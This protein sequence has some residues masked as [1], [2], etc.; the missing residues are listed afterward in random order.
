M[1]ANHLLK[2]SLKSFSKPAAWLL[3]G[4]LVTQLVGCQSSA[5]PESNGDE[6]SQRKVDLLATAK[7]DTAR[8]LPVNNELNLTGKITFNQ[9]KVVKVFPLVGGHIEEV[10]TDL[11]DFVKR[12]QTLAIIRSGDMADLEQEAVAAKGQLAVARKNL[13]VTEDMSKAGLAAQKDLIAA[14]EQMQAAQGEVN[15]VAARKGILGGSGSIYVVKAPTDGFVVEKNAAQGMELRSDDPEN[16]FTI[17][18]LDQVWVLA[19]V[20]ES[21]LANVKEGYAATI[22][23]L[24]YPDRVFKGKIDKIFNVLDADSKTM[25]VRVTLLNADYTLKPEMFANVRVEYAGQEQRIGIPAKA[26][27]FDK[28]RNFVVAVNS[29]NQ[30][31]VREVDIFKTI[32]DIAYLN[33]GLKPG[34]RVVKQNQLLIYS[35]LG[36]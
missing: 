19:N 32:G 28:S 9:D 8:L 16:L 31:V 13:Q 24:S 29:H 23:T 2:P 30:P 36:N 35:A 12:G 34:D 6:V 21:D 15:R 22:T 10:K 1:K 27:V 14:R 3:A 11:G 7:I 17:S 33:S 20:Y 25:K 4:L 26:I 5:T 18:N